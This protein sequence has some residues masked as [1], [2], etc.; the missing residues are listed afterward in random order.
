MAA[1]TR[2]DD[3]LETALAKIVGDAVSQW[4]RVQGDTPELLYHYTDVSGLI[5]ICSSGSLRGTNLRF[6]N[7]AS[8]LSHSRSLMLQV[9]GDTRA[10]ASSPAQIELIDEIE[11]VVARQ[12][13]G[14]PDFYSVSFSANGDLLSQWRGYGSAGGGYA[15]GFD[16]AE[17]TRPRSPYPQP[18]RFLNRVIYEPELQ[19]EILGRIAADMLALFATIDP[20]GEAMTATRARLFSA[21]GED[22][23]VRVSAVPL[24]A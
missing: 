8:E 22:V 24:R 11:R 21:L 19:L 7:D 5:G 20:A 15:I 12:W 16:T 2:Q 13:S 17:L 3:P 9:L 6:M 23:A 4:D 14:H 10:Q 1:V 18:A